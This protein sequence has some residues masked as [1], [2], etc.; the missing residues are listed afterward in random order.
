MK[1]RL[2]NLILEDAFGVIFVSYVVFFGLEF[3]LEGFVSN[4]FDLNILLVGLVVVGFLSLWSK[5]KMSDMT[6]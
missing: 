3:L 2:I 6:T 4:N 1:R 5:N